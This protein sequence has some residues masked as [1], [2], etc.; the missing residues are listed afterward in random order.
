M[1]FIANIEEDKD[2]NFQIMNSNNRSKWDNSG[3]VKATSTSY[4]S[5]KNDSSGVHHAKLTNA[6][7]NWSIQQSGVFLSDRSVVYGT[8]GISSFGNAFGQKNTIYPSEFSWSVTA[9]SSWVHAETGT[10]NSIIGTTANVKLTGRT[11]STLQLI[12]QWGS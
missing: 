5:V 9:P 6:N 1:N 8:T 11:T 4:F 2:G 12:N 10:G 7:G 3:S